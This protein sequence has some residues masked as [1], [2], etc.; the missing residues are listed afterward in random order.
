MSEI[1]KTDK[2]LVNGVCRDAVFFHLPEE[3]DGYLS[4]WFLSSFS[5]EGKVF[6]SAE[7]ETIFRDLF[8]EMKVL[9]CTG[10]ISEA[11][12]SNPQSIL[13]TTRNPA[14][15]VS[16]GDSS[17]LH[18]KLRSMLLVREKLLEMGKTG[19]SITVANPETPSYSPSSP[20]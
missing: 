2:L 5:L 7:Q 14:F 3:P 16:I 13:L 15:T 6:S 4:N 1:R 11:D 20:Q 18:A 10:M 17:V 19:G 9:G 8:M 12:L